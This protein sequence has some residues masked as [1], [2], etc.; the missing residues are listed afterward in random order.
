[1]IEK[2]L[3]LYIM[4]E[5]RCLVKID[6]LQYFLKVI[7]Y[8]RRRKVNEIRILWVDG[9]CREIAAYIFIRAEQKVTVLHYVIYYI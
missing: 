5:F 9:Y 1:M 8:E 2:P 3:A 7:G 4:R 6:T